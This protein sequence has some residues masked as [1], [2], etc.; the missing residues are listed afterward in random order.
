MPVHWEVPQLSVPP[1]PLGGVPQAAEP[2]YPAF[3]Q[4]FAVQ[5]HTLAVPPPPQLAPVP[6]QVPHEVTVFELPQL[7][8]AVT[9][10]RNAVA[11]NGAVFD[12]RF[13]SAKVRKEVGGLLSR[14]PSVRAT[15]LRQEGCLSGDQRLRGSLGRASDSSSPSRVRPDRPLGQSGQGEADRGMDPGHVDSALPRGYTLIESRCTLEGDT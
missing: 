6:L 5:P 8:F 12:T 10:P 1:H 4:V 2:E 7:L 14:G 9:E 11:R 15:R 13:A 3:A